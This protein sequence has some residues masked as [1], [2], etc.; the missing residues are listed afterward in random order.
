M[1]GSV[2]YTVKFR[3]ES[4]TEVLGYVQHLRESDRVVCVWGDVRG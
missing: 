1:H 4:V 3:V 2:Y